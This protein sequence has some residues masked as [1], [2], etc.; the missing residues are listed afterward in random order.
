MRDRAI[1]LPLV[2]GEYGAMLAE[3]TMVN[4]SEQVNAF[5]SGE[6][7]TEHLTEPAMLILDDIGAEHDPSKCGAEKLYMV[8]ERREW[9]WTL[10]TTNISASHWEQ[11]FERRISDRLLR[12]SAIVDLTKVPS[13]SINT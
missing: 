2:I 3:C 8:L 12:N 11:R 9:K 1:D 10:I 13:Y 7:E 4:W 6:W 5:K